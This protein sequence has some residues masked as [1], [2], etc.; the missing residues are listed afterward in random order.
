MLGHMDDKLSSG[1]FTVCLSHQQCVSHTIQ[2]VS[3]TI[4]VTTFYMTMNNELEVT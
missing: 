4:H 1:F 3:H 2:C